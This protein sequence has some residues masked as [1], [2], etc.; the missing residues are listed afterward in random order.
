MKALTSVAVAVLTN[1]SLLW[2]PEVRAGLAEADLVMPSLAAGDQPSFERVN[3]PHPE[4]SCERM[5]DGL[6]TFAQGYK[7]KIWLEVFILGGITDRREELR[8]IAAIVDRIRP[9]RVQL[10]TVSRPLAEACALATPREVLESLLR[11]FSVLLC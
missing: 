6:V 10:N 5:V 7:G 11:L 4:I 9:T 1:G 3:R 2:K 8:R